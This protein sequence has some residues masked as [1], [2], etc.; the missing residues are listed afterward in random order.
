MEKMNRTLPTVLGLAVVVS[1]VVIGGF[2][3][4]TESSPGNPSTLG[5]SEQDEAALDPHGTRPSDREW[6]NQQPNPGAA[7][8]RS[9][10]E[11]AVTESSLP[12]GNVS[13]GEMLGAQGASGGLLQGED[14]GRILPVDQA[15]PFDHMHDGDQLILR[16]QTVGGHYLYR[17]RF[18]LHGTSGE[19]ISLQLP[20]GKLEKD[21]YFG[22]V[23]IFENPLEVSVD[24]NRSMVNG[25]A[26]ARFRVSYQGCAKMGYCYPPQQRLIEIS[27]SDA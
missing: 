8:E 18:A 22:D 6:L 26:G 23:Y 17:H 27:G 15:F 2:A 19:T 13:L 12:S 5:L 3:V 7:D 1:T 11:G 21:P 10:A 16:W 25:E 14:E 9:D 20:E 4:L 24:I